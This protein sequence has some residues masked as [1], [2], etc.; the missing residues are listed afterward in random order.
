MPQITFVRL[1]AFAVVLFGS[2]VPASAGKTQIPT[3]GNKPIPTISCKQACMFGF[4]NCRQKVIGKNTENVCCTAKQ[5]E[6]IKACLGALFKC[7]YPCPSGDPYKN[8][9]I[10][11]TE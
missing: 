3:G 9:P 2:V 1:I 8:I 4:Y 7:E 6:Q 11:K 5:T 10:P